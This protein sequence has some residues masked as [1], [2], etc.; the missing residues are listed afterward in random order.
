MVYRKLH[1]D[2]LLMAENSMMLKYYNNVAP[3]VLPLWPCVRSHHREPSNIDI[4]ALIGLVVS[5]G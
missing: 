1:A 2:S 3:V 5:F 4:A